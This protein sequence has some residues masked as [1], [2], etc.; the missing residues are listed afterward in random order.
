MGVEELTHR[1]RKKQRTRELIVERAMELFD[2]RGFEHVPIAEIAA[3]A[4]I[5]PR[6]FFSYFPSKEDVVFHDFDVILD[7]LTR[8]IAE[9]GDGEST[10]DALRAFI[11]ELLAQVDHD[12]PAQQCRRRVIRGSPALQQHDRELM[13]R[14]EV[15][16][17]DGLAQDLG[18]PPDSLRARVV[19]AA[20]AAGLG[21]L[22]QY[23]DK[24]NPPDD[25]M[26]MFDEAFVF[27]R[28]GVEALQRHPP[29]S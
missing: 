6:T 17:A 15:A 28:G 29:P 13:S 19:A 11:V 9:R 22:E 21:E 27:I 26:S 3:A 14:I 12:D 25:K 5:A 1:E 7:A 16:I 4:D 23:M 24:D 8:R 20:A 2:E 18:A 10:I